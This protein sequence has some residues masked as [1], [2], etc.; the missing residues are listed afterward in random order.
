MEVLS[1]RFLPNPLEDV[2]V[3]KS[4][5]FADRLALFDILGARDFGCRDDRSTGGRGGQAEEKMALGSI[6]LAT[7]LRGYISGKFSQTAGPCFR[8]SLRAM[9][10]ALP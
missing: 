9:G 8:L 7:V 3:G 6:G 10:L 2:T 1:L 4:V 5:L